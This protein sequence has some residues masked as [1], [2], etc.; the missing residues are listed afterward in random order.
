MVAGGVERW[1]RCGAFPRKGWT[2]VLFIGEVHCALKQG[3]TE[4]GAATSSSRAAHGQR[5]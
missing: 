2:G 4:G 3:G 1:K 5:G